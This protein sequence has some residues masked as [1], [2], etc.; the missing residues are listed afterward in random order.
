MIRDN[1][2]RTALAVVNRRRILGVLMPS[3]TGVTNTPAA[4]P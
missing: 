1:R 4:A 2:S 3:R